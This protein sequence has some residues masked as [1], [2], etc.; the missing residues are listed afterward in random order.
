MHA[1]SK[2]VV[3]SWFDNELISILSTTFNPIDPTGATFGL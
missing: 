3:V 1:S 2:L